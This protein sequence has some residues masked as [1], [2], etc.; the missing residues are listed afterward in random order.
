MNSLLSAPGPRTVCPALLVAVLGLSWLSSPLAQRPEA[1]DA[2]WSLASLKGYNLSDKQMASITAQ[3]QSDVPD[4]VSTVSFHFA[5]A[6]AYG[7]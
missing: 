6:R 4:A 7:G 1:G 2:W 5:L 3:L